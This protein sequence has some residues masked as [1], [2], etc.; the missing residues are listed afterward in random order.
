MGIC[1]IDMQGNERNM[2]HTNFTLWNYCHAKILDINVAIN[3]E[4][5][6]GLPLKIFCFVGESTSLV[7]Q[8][9][10]E[11]ISQIYNSVSYFV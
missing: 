4:N 8:C 7:H 9:T 1:P 6:I 11:E 5:I 10:N 3:F 2:I